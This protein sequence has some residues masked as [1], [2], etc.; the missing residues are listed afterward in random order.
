MREIRIALAQV[1]TILLMYP[2]A[3]LMYITTVIIGKIYPEGSDGRFIADDALDNFESK[4][5][6]RH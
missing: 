2:L 5:G 1:M 3:I 4:I 6:I